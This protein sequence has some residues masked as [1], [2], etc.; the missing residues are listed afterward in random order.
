[1]YYAQSTIIVT[2]RPE[3]GRRGG[4]RGE[5]AR[6]EGG[7]KERGGGG[8]VEKGQTESIREKAQR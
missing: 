8:G 7:E 3:R 6:G 1:M 4:D 2:S 5:R